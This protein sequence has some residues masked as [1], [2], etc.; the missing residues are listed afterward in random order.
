MH[1]VWL[2]EQ[3]ATFTLHIINRLVFYNQDGKC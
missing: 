3:T 1:S 2:S